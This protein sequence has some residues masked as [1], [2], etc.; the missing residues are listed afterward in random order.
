MLS[1]VLV[2]HQPCIV[3]AN[4]VP[5]TRKWD[6]GCRENHS[7]Y[8]LWDI[9]PF[10]KAF[11]ISHFIEPNHRSEKNTTICPAIAWRQRKSKL[12]PSPLWSNYGYF[13]MAGCNCS[14]HDYVP[15]SS[16]LCKENF[17]AIN[18]CLWL[19]IEAPVKLFSGKH[20]GPC[21]AIKLESER[22]LLPLSEF[23][24]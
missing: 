19:F 8:S 14:S 20:P 18:V 24:W 11:V 21:H 7:V 6:V 13:I 16:S 4:I 17:A 15:L 3:S 23:S 1:L 10:S 12:T 9:F 5:R 2:F 22:A